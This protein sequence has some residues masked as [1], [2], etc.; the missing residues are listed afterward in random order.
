MSGDLKDASRAA[1][2]PHGAL[3]AFDS[4]FLWGSHC[5][6]GWVGT[7]LASIWE[8]IGKDVVRSS[9]LTLAS[10]VEEWTGLL[11][12]QAGGWSGW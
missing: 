10:W 4:G 5:R 9:I 8:Q 11:G 3:K 2:G 12:S 7:N 6:T 1:A